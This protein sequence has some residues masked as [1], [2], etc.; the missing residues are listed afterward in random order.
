[1]HPYPV[2]VELL[3]QP[4][5]VLGITGKSI[6]RLRDDQVDLAVADVLQQIAEA[7]A[8]TPIA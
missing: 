6:Q 1:M 5:D 3:A 2:I 7:G 4:S 8:V